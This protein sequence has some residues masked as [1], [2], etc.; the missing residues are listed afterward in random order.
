M[1]EVIDI[2]APLLTEAGRVCSSPQCEGGLVPKQ[3]G[4]SAEGWSAGGGGAK[5]CR[6]ITK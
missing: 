2:T 4:A 3:A 1:S 6:L 5:P